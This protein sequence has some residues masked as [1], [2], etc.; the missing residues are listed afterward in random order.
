MSRDLDAADLT[1]KRLLSV[2]FD[3]FWQMIYFIQYLVFH[4]SFSEAKSAID[5]TYI[6]IYETNPTRKIKQ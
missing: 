5:A 1:V 3:Y 4:A 2:W 6:V